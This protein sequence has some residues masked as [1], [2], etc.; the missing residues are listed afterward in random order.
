MQNTH[1]DGVPEWR[2]ALA[3]LHFLHSVY[4]RQHIDKCEAMNQG[5]FI[6]DSLV[7]TLT[8][9]TSSPLQFCCGV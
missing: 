1:Q 9:T 4:S 5:A 7:D 3:E 6:G 2:Q 8:S